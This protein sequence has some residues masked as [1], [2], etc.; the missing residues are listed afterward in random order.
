MASLLGAKRI[1]LLDELVPKARAFAMLVNPAA[2][3]TAGEVADVQTAARVLKQEIHILNASAESEFEPAFEAMAKLQVA[4]FLLA[5]T[6][7]S[8][9]GPSSSWRSRAHS[10]FLQFIPFESSLSPGAS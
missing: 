8:T 6:R 5:P 9:A 2:T 7:F 4:G 10:L 1:E 3:T